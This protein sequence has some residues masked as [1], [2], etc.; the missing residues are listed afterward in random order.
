MSGNQNLPTTISF[1]P[2]EAD[3]HTQELR[4]HGVRLRLPG[5]SFQILE[6]LLKRPGELVTREELRQALW[7]SD[8]HVD[9]ERGVNA[10]VNRLREVMGDS[11]DSPHLIETL[12]RRGYRFI[13][14]LNP[15]L[16]EI[17]PLVSTD[18]ADN[19]SEFS[20]AAKTKATTSSRI[21]WMQIT[22]WAFV[23]VACVCALILALN[24]NRSHSGL[25]FAAPV[26]FTDS[27]GFEYCPQFSPDG[28]QI[29]FAWSGDPATGSKG[30]DLYVKVI[31]GENLLRL[32]QHPSESICAAWSPDGTQIAFYRLSGADTGIYLVSALGGP[33]RKLRSTKGGYG[34]SWSANGKWIAY[35]DD[36][37]PAGLPGT[38]ITTDPSRLYLLSLD[39]LESR[40]IPHA[41]ECLVEQNPVFS[42]S[43]DRLAYVCLLKA[44]PNEIG[45]YSVSLP[46]GS[47]KLLA[48]F[49]TGWSFPAGIAWTENDER[50]IVS[51]PLVGN[52]LQLDEVTLND[53]VF[54]K[55]PFGKGACCPAIA[56]KGDKLAYSVSAGDRSVIWRKDLRNPEGSGTRLMSSTYENFF[57]QYSP[58]GKH[59]AF[60]SNRGGPSEVWMTDPDGTNL[61]RMS[62]DKSSIA[63]PPQ[64]SPDGRK[65]AFDSRQSGHP[66]VYIVDISER[67]PRR[68]ITN[69]SDAS[70]PSW[71]HDGN[72]LYFEAT[73]DQ[74]IF[75]CPASG[76]DAMSLSAKSGAFPVESYDGQTVYFVSPAEGTELHMVSLKQ[77]GT[78]FPVQGIPALVRRELY[79]VVP[80]G[81][82]FLSV[83]KPKFI[84]YFDFA[85]RQVRQV[86]NLEK[87]YVVGLAVS[88]DGRWILYTQPTGAEANSDIML[89]D[90]FH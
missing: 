4:K 1:G 69:V 54:R 14:M 71:S 49:M 17:A 38:V 8:T 29:A 41:E 77:L 85:T 89:V 48:R 3:L 83:D 22:V 28:S 46:G 79:T 36:T 68:L 53:G 20:A 75:R 27:P 56:A 19:T 9:F 67:L 16:S 52:D 61:V 84:Q 44:N 62:D 57:P 26:P 81:I 80:G 18:S 13:G 33:E 25:L 42:H 70:T 72:W 5:Q 76:G 55:L 24:R 87:E 10:A 78:A 40:Q 2:F 74:R 21:R 86:F 31:H 32:T 37:A 34:I 7:P 73:S 82:Y 66:E 90:H 39:T 50:M 35:P 65:L 59:I 47:P 64:W 12:P 6:M 15:P 43:D 58:D 60:V 45:I 30:D 51:R 23:G 11:A 88:P 63:G